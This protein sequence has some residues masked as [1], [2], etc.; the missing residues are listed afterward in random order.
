MHFCEVETSGN[1]VGFHEW[2]SG[3]K[4]TKIKSYNN[5]TPPK[6]TR[7]VSK[8]WHSYKVKWHSWLEHEPGRIM[9]LVVKHRVY[10][11]QFIYKYTHPLISWLFGSRTSPVSKVVA[12]PSSKERCNIGADASHGIGLEAADMEGRAWRL[13][14][15]HRGGTKAS[16]PPGN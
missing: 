5:L 15:R 9:V 6:Q 16:D 1:L 8:W 4:Q 14:E 12:I 3:K 11:N 13:R 7:K 10:N 2:N